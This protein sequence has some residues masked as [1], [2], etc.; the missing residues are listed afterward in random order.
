MN[1]QEIKTLYT[2]LLQNAGI[3]RVMDFKKERQLALDTRK[4]IE[5]SLKQ[6]E[7]IRPR[8]I[9]EFVGQYQKQVAM[10]EHLGILKPGKREIIGIDGE[11]Y[12]LP[13][14]FEF[15]RIL[16]KEKEKVL[17][18]KEQG[19]GRI[20]LVP[21]GMPLETLIKIYENALKSHFRAGKLFY[22]KEKPEDPDEPADFDENE[23]VWTSGEWLDQNKPAG[24]RGKD[25]SGDIVY[26]ANKL[27]QENH[28]GLTKKEVL[29]KQ[30][31]HKSASV[32]WRILMVE[33]GDVIPREKN[34]KIIGG[35]KQIEAGKSANEYLA[36]LK[37]K[38][39]EHEQGMS[40]ED[41]LMLAL[42]TLEEKNQ[43]LDDFQGKG[44]YCRLPGSFNFRSGW[45]AGAYWSRA[46]RQASLSS[47]SPDRQRP[48]GG[49]RSAVDI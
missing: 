32:G 28:G 2:T 38:T 9:V 39:Y 5:S 48:L 17:K 16:M 37:E 40:L 29:Q 36:K 49:L 33:T 25:V 35:R 13:D 27:E 14:K 46:G 19:F 1:C 31:Q 43:V 11:K 10:M 15:I 6:L 30:K 7:A 12:P 24:K 8:E 4:L 41:W 45:L 34:G 26:Y 44:C 21:I 20:L 18:K 47:V 3:F 22:P 42:M 23:P